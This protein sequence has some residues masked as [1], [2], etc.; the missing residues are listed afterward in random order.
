MC[1]FKTQHLQINALERN[2]T[3]LRLF[4]M[5]R[6]QRELD[7]EITCF[8]QCSSHSAFSVVDENFTFNW[9]QSPHLQVTGGGYNK[10]TLHSLPF[11]FSHK[12][13]VHLPRIGHSTK[14]FNWYGTERLIRKHLASRGVPTFM[15]LLKLMI[16]LTMSLSLYC[17]CCWTIQTFKF[18]M[19]LE[20]R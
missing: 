4:C 11:L 20:R 13:S 17:K 16:S 18:S 12:A 7:T 8:C 5:I 3:S 1:V 2:L 9:R 14:G 19:N 6:A 15:Y 10:L